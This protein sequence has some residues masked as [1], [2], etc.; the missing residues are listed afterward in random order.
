MAMYLLDRFSGATH[1]WKVVFKPKAYATH[2]LGT[3]AYQ[4]KLTRRPQ[5]GC[6]AP[7]S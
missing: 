3:S 2:I 4:L 1:T 7:Q 5:L 6:A